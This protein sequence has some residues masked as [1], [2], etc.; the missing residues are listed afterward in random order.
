MM[1]FTPALTD[2]L[3]ACCSN[4]M[5][6]GLTLQGGNRYLAAV[7]SEVRRVL[8][9]GLPFV[10]VQSETA[11]AT[12]DATLRPEAIALGVFGGIAGVAALLI[13]GQVISRRIRL[14][15][16]DLSI[17]R[18]LGASPTMN[19]SDG[20]LGT[21]GAIVW[22]RSS[23]PSWP[24]GSRPWRPWDRCDPSCRRTCTS[25]GPLWASVSPSWPSR[26]VRSRW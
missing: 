23:P 9:K 12:A 4:D 15:T 25:I 22:V 21:A 17:A 8:P 20:L 18:A 1:L 3:L 7:E 11:E 16:T 10:Y 5:I 13:G 14:R 2:K 6:S 19:F 26:W 24:S